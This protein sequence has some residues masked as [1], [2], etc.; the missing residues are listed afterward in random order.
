MLIPMVL[1]IFPS[2]VMVVMGPAII[3]IVRVVGPMLAGGK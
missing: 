1:C 3:Q 2:V